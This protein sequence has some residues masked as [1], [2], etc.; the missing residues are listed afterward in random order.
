MDARDKAAVVAAIR[1]CIFC[2]D[3]TRRVQCTV[4]DPSYP[5]M[6]SPGEDMQHQRLEKSQQCLQQQQ[7]KQEAIRANLTLRSSERGLIV[8][9]RPD[10]EGGE[11]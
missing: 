7:Q 4:R 11:M 9:L 1:I 2:K 5:P 8:F 10:K 3:A 6:L